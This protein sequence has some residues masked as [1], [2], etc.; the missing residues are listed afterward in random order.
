MATEAKNENKRDLTDPF[1]KSLKGRNGQYIVWDKTLRSFGVRV[2][3]KGAVSFIVVGRTP[4][5]KPVKATVGRYP[6]MKLAE[7]R[8]EAKTIKLQIKDGTYQSA[9]ENAPKAETTPRSAITFSECVDEYIET[10]AKVKMRERSWKE[11]SY[12]LNRRFK[13]V[14]GDKVLGDITEDDLADIIDSVVEEGK[15]SAANHAVTDIKR[16]F[17]WAADRRRK[18]VKELPAAVLEKPF[19]DN[20]RTR[21]LNEQELGDIYIAAEE[22]GYPFADMVQLL[23]LTGARRAQI[24]SLRWDKVNFEDRWI[25]SHQKNGLPVNSCYCL[26]LLLRW[27]SLELSRPEA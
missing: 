15:P 20:R 26:F 17:S 10:Y 11:L 4:K 24:A 19:D 1:L 25:W 3:Q 9:K 27:I 5:G 16:F 13:Q 14:L 22:M 8:A 21:V 18:Y 6:E 23:I 12:V 2:S 7:A